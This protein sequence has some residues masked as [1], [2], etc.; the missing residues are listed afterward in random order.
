MFLTLYFELYETYGL[1]LKMK[2][3]TADSQ[4]I[5]ENESTIALALSGG[6]IRAM[7]FH[8][9]VLKYLAEKNKLESIEHVSTVSGGSLIV[10]LILKNNGMV[11][12]SSHVFLKEIIINVKQQLCSKSMMWGMARQLKNPKSF[13]FLLSRSNLLAKTLY[14]EWGVDC[15][16]S[17]IPDVPMWHINGTTAETGKRFRFK[18]DDFGEYSLGYSKDT[19]K[20]PLAKAIA[21]SAAFPGGIGPLVINASEYKWYK[22]PWGE[23]KTSSKETIL[24]HSLLHLYD[25]GV[26]DNLGLE[27]FFDMGTQ[28]KKDDISSETV[29][30]VSDAGASLKQKFIFKKL[31][32]WR[33]KHVTD[34]ISD[35][36]RA[37]RVR[38]FINF[39]KNNPK[40]GFYIYIKES[41]IPKENENASFTQAFPT[42]LKKL[43]E[44]QFDML[45]EHGYE[46]C[47]VRMV[48]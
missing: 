1:I 47:K 4:I 44:K 11:W 13:K 16:L 40:K 7:I 20:F 15:S 14:D 3:D 25:G 34:I 24:D 38:S 5:N 35:Q 43:N 9:G 18:K 21:V 31:S 36:S 2:V 29:I 33:L 26:Y 48:L 37:L 12:P 32:P 23:P 22:R 10:G 46:A 39:S 42:T 45:L 17:E 8:L 19:Y 41:K 6:G 27:P 28:E 30:I